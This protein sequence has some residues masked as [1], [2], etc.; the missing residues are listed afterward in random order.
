MSFLCYQ[1]PFI[2][3]SVFDLNALVN[4][5]LLSLLCLVKAEVD[6]AST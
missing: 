6:E 2:T 1:Q 4:F 5:F 3:L